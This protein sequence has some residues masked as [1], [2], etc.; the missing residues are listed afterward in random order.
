MAIREFTLP[1]DSAR[2][3]NREAAAAKC[4]GGDVPVA[5][6][7]VRELYRNRVAQFGRKHL[8][9]R[10]STRLHPDDLAQ[11]IYCS[12]FHATRGNDVE[13]CDQTGFWQWLAVVAIDR[14]RRRCEEQGQS[15]GHSDHDTASQSAEATPN[16]PSQQMPTSAD[17]VEFA[18]LLESVLLSV[19][20]TD[21]QILLLRLNGNEPPE[22]AERVLLDT[23]TVRSRLLRIRQRIARV[24]DETPPPLD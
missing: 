5:T 24:L 6:Q 19:E 14:T 16:S 11:S 12:I 1:E 15:A 9:E 4:D 7:G 2:R 20:P 17:V 10:L 13:A 3:Q 22:I 18:S 23:Q 8:S 21:L